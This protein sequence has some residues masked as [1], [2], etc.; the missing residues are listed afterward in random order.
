MRDSES[1]K[2]SLQLQD[3]CAFYGSVQALDHIDLTMG[4][5]ERVG[6]IGENGAGQS[7]LLRAISRLHYRISGSIS[8]GDRSLSRCSPDEV[9]RRGITFVRDGGQVFETL[10]IEEHLQL[11]IRLGRRRGR[12]TQTEG[13]VLEMFP[14]LARLQSSTKA[15]Y[16]SGGQ[17]QALCLAMASASGSACL[18]LDEP[19][20]GLAESTAGE[21]FSVINQLTTTGVSLLIVEQDPRWL[22]GLVDR[23]I[24][25]SAGRILDVSRPGRLD[26]MAVPVRGSGAG[27]STD[28]RN[29]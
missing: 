23:I 17:R 10:T 19:S 16:L 15:G 28:P 13:E 29:P 5:G 24:E 27:R 8:F 20:A 4:P 11:A 25:I 3:L 7:T 21:I 18:L 26:E 2:G 6:I 12:Q 9:A 22:T 1:T 14:V